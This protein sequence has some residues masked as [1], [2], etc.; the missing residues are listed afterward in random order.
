MKLVIKRYR[1]VPKWY[2]S[3]TEIASGRWSV[4][5]LNAFCGHRAVFVRFLRLKC[6]PVGFTHTTTAPTAPTAATTVTPATTSSAAT[7]S[8]PP[9][10]T[11]NPKLLAS[12]GWNGKVKNT[13]SGRL[14]NTYKYMKSNQHKSR[15]CA[16]CVR[17]EIRRTSVVDDKLFNG[18]VSLPHL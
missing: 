8:S 1:S 10:A 2:L 14:A 4:F 16:E 12:S 5:E 3:C 13:S 18:N 15:N 17:G 7:S 11:T 9:A 6:I